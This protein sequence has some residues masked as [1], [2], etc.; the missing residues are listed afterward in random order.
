MICLDFGG[1]AFDMLGFVHFESMDF[2]S[3]VTFNAGHHVDA[4]FVGS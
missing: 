4:G 1:F 3:L 2:S